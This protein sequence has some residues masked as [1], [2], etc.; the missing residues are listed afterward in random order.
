MATPEAFEAVSAAWLRCGWD[1]K[2]VYSFTWLGRP[3]IQLPE[4]M[5]RVQEVITAVRPDVIIETG[6]AHGGSLVFHASLC[7][8]LG[9]GRVIGIDIEIRPHNRKAIEAHDLFP[10]IRLIE[11]SSTA[12]TVVDQVKALV[13]PGEA[14]LV[15]L[16]SKHTRD[17][18]LAELRAYSPLVSEGSYIV[19]CDGIMRQVVGAPRTQE[20]WAWN[21]PI[22]AIEEFLRET[23]EFVQETPSFA[24]NEG[25]IGTPVTY[26]PKGYL[27]RIG[28][29][30][31]RPHQNA[32]QN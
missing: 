10:L 6:I 21:N 12:P 13:K 15:I 8:A 2:H 27:R 17:H 11:G 32:G 18:V 20:D 5:F 14:V 19:A 7:K 31:I 28:A 25:L 9:K 29:Q 24:F 4:D 1:V 26:W 3:I 23:K 16:D 30:V 22:S